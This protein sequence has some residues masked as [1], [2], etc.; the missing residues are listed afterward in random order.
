MGTCSFAIG[1]KGPQ[2]SI[3]AAPTRA[4]KLQH[5]GGY[6][7]DLETMQRILERDLNATVGRLVMHYKECMSEKPKSKQEIGLALLLHTSV[8]A[9]SVESVLRC[10]TKNAQSTAASRE[11]FEKRH[12]SSNPRQVAEGILKGLSVFTGCAAALQLP[13]DL[14]LAKLKMEGLRGGRGGGVSD[15][16]SAMGIE[17]IVDMETNVLQVLRASSVVFLRS[18]SARHARSP[19]SACLLLLC[20]WRTIPVF[21]VLQEKFVRFVRMAGLKVYEL[22][23][24][25]QLELP[26]SGAWSLVRT[27]EVAAKK[28]RVSVCFVVSVVCPLVPPAPVWRPLVA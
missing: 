8:R 26:A 24:G 11:Y 14:S 20:L 13:V 25:R 2:K 5:E 17:D 12:P 10:G 4:E 23:E 9:L 18:R 7:R 21:R 1:G 16:V 19:R 22:G 28:L 27:R 6:D 15:Q 3:S